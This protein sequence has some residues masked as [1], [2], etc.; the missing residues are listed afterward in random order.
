[1][2]GDFHRAANEVSRWTQPPWYI[3][4]S[5]TSSVVPFFIDSSSNF[6]LEGFEIY[7]NV[8]KMTRASQG[9]FKDENGYEYPVNVYL[10]E[11]AGEMSGVI[12][13]NSTEL[14]HRGRV[15]APLGERTVS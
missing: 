4:D 5:H 6:N 8:D 2:K 15:L 3:A 11:A 1:M 9:M 12:T 14:P 7:G 13:A 10:K